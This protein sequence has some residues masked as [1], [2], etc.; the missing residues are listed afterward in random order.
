VTLEHLERVATP[1]KALEI[2]ELAL[3]LGDLDTV[4]EESE[5]YALFVCG[6]FLDAVTEKL[7]DAEAHAVIE[8]L[9]SLFAHH[10]PRAGSGFRRRDVVL[11]KIAIEQAKHRVVILASGDAQ[12]RRA[13]REQLDDIL[14]VHEAASPAMLMQLTED[15]LDRE[16]VLVVDGEVPGLRASMLVTLARLLPSGAS[17]VVRGAVPAALND[18]DVQF[19]ALDPRAPDADIVRSCVGV[20][21]SAAKV[22]IIVVADCDLAWRSELV[23]ELRAEGYDVVTC[24]AGMTAL[25]TCVDRKADLVITNLEMPDLNGLAI[26]R[27]LRLR[28]SVDAPEIVLITSSGLDADQV[29]VSA[30]LSQDDPIGG[31]VS[32][33]ARVLARRS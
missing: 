18:V 7:G 27:L 1:A 19:T 20:A 2:V 24:S 16:I 31:V 5:A 28:M 8:D 30:V 14:E 25:E 23:R 22:P 13:L 17:M 12:K 3:A 10:S 29:G 9:S 4:P 26:A 33:A 15:H 21:P 11:D 32:A 6:P